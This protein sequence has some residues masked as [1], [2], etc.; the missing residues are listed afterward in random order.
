MQEHVRYMEECFMAGKVLIY[1]PV[2]EPDAPFGMGV[3]ETSDEA[4]AR[5]L[6]ENDPS[7]KT[8][9]NTFEIYPMRV[10][11]AQASRIN[12]S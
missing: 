4:E 1:G 7:V 9:L 10:G 5:R 6:M 12:P 11:A 8:G 2:L 3:L